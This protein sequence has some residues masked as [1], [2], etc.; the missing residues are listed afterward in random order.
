MDKWCVL[1]SNKIPLDKRQKMDYI[2]LWEVIKVK[3]PFKVFYP[4]GSLKIEQ[5][6]I[7]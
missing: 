2:I 4:F 1:N 3:K 7:W 5:E 6:T